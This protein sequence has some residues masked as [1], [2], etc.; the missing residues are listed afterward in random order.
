LQS[1]VCSSESRDVL[2][3]PP[4]SEANESDIKKSGVQVSRG[5]VDAMLVRAE[6]AARGDLS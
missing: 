5:V 6:G 2:T 1:R 3:P 4:H